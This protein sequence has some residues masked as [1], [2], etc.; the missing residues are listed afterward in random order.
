MPV[1]EGLYCCDNLEKINGGE[2]IGEEGRETPE[3]VEL[4]SK[5]IKFKR[6]FKN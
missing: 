3:P 5:I 1:C 4:Y 6:K 2:R